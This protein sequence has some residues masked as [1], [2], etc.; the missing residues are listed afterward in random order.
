ME[1]LDEVPRDTWEEEQGRVDGLLWL[2]M[3]AAVAV[4]GAR[5]EWVRECWRRLALQGLEWVEVR[6]RL[7]GVMWIDMIQDKGG[8]EVFDS[9]KEA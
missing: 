3:I 5:E 7:Q 1:F 4:F 8:K 9:L 2:V 6:K